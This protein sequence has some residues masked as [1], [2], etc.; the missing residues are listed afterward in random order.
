MPIFDLALRAGRRAKSSF[1]F[2]AERGVRYAETDGS[3]AEF[4]GQT[5]GKLEDTAAAPFAIGAFQG[6]Q[7]VVAR[8]S[9]RAQ[10]EGARGAMKEAQAGGGMQGSQQ[11]ARKENRRA[12][13]L[14]GMGGQRGVQQIV[15][16]GGVKGGQRAQASQRGVKGG[17]FFPQER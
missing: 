4:G 2:S 17:I 3:L 16:V 12:A 9:P 11:G 6:D 13:I 14:P 10:G 1:P 5:A 15:P 7:G 8:L